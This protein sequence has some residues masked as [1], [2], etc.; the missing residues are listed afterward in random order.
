MAKDRLTRSVVGAFVIVGG[1]AVEVAVGASLA[2]SLLD[3]TVGVALLAVALTDPRQRIDRVGLLTAVLWYLATAVATS[4]G[5]WHALDYAL[6]LG[7]RGPLLHQLFRPTLAAKR[8]IVVPMAIA[9]LAPLTPFGW[10]GHATAAAAA[11]LATLI[12]V[13]AWRGP[14]TELRRADSQTALVLC[15]LS[16]IWGA[17]SFGW[18][19][20]NLAQV[21]SDG[22]VLIAAVHLFRRRGTRWLTETMADMVIELGHTGRPSAP[23]S[24]SLAG[25]L[26]DPGLWIATYQA[27]A[28]WRDEFG[29]SIPASLLDQPADRVT[30]VPTPSGGELALVHGPEGAG[31]SDLSQSAARAAALR[32]ESVRLTAEVRRRAEDVRHSAAR[33]LTVDEQ[34]REALAKRL[35][36]GPLRGLANVRA[37][38]DQTEPGAVPVEPILERLDELSEDLNRLAHGLRPHAVTDRSLPEALRT[39][40]AAAALPT[41]LNLEGPLHHLT[42]QT[43]ALV[44]FFAA[45][46]LT[47][48]ARH[49]GATATTFTV[50]MD[51]TVRIEIL[52]NGHGGATTTDGRGLQGLADRVTL[53]GGVFTIDSPPGGPTR[54]FAELGNNA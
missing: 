28:G 20:G 37:L 48:I 13:A 12:T 36:T 50:A 52:D 17:A 7:Y 18:V 40:V 53:V 5:W 19:T 41:T 11:A 54:I 6:V 25:V 42:E 27:D 32:L 9:Y 1:G 22:A 51:N 26:A 23:L 16:A 24:A 47:N 8:R 2:S 39:L 4:P 15:G 49:S 14:P 31:D 29:H 30:I 44:Y 21:L 33:L 43:K 10:S 3:W 35:T 38:L 45:E 34:E 46:C